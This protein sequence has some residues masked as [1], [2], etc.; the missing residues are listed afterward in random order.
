MVMWGYVEICGRGGAGRMGSG[1]HV[2]LEKDLSQGRAGRP[3]SAGRLLTLAGVSRAAP[4]VEL[5]DS[6]GSGTGG[7]HTLKPAF[8]KYTAPCA[9]R[10]PKRWPWKTLS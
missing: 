9:L 10:T 5:E 2:Y 4:M 8:G 3:P 1:V 6:G 7:R